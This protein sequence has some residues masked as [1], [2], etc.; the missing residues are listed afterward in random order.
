M[1]FDNVAL[2]SDEFDLS[3]VHSHLSSSVILFLDE[4][5]P[6]SVL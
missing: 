2:G 6:I 5:T 3:L 1:F 4:C